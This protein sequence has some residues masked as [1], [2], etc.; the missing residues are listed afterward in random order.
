MPRRDLLPALALALPLEKLVLVATLARRAARGVAWLLMLGT[1]LA[2]TP[3]GFAGTV[4]PLAL[5]FVRSLQADDA[6]AP[7]TL[8][9]LGERDDLVAAELM[10]STARGRRSA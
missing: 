2:V 7:R 8:V 10:P 3:W 1:W 4:V 5:V 6:R 9:R